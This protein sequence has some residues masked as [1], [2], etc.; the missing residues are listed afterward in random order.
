MPFDGMVYRH[1]EAGAIHRGDEN[2]RW[3]EK[4]LF[5]A[6]GLFSD[7][8]FVIIKIPNNAQIYIIWVE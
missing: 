8:I 5:M 6:N 4:V 2:N 3:P 7:T 1:R